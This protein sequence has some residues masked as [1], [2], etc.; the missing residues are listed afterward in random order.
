MFAIVYSDAGGLVVIP[1][2]IM[3]IQTRLMFIP[4]LVFVEC[5]IRSEMS[6]KAVAQDVL[7][8]DDMNV[9]YQYYLGGRSYLNS[10]T[11]FRT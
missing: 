3:R 5:S 7:L 11:M 4:L 6:P 9:A 2:L 8:V 1:T 10:R